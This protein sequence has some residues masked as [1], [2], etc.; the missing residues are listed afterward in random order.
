MGQFQLPHYLTWNQAVEEAI[1]TQLCHSLRPIIVM[2]EGKMLQQNL[3]MF[4]SG[5]GDPAAYY[6]PCVSRC[7]LYWDFAIWLPWRAKM[8]RSNPILDHW[9]MQ[10]F[11]EL[12]LH[13]YDSENVISLLGSCVLERHQSVIDVFPLENRNIIRAVYRHLCGLMCTACRK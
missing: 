6:F 7:S 13:Y 5:T 11:Q 9:C 2:H 8:E 1:S 12:K 3:K 10:S 4:P